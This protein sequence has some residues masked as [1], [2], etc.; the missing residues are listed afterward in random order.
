MY[1]GLPIITNKIPLAERK[2]VT[3]H[4][5]GCIGLDEQSWRVD[6]FVR[7]AGQVV[8]LPQHEVGWDEKLTSCETG[9]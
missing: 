9:G 4:L 2:G 5:L 6:K 8:R 7:K 3:H 1:D